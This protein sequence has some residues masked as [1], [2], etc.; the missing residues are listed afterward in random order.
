[1]KISGAIGYL[2][3]RGRGIGHGQLSSRMARYHPGKCPARQ[4]IA[5]DAQPCDLS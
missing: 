1:V 2:P 3:I 4:S 5:R